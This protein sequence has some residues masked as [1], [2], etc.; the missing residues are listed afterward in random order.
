MAN[1]IKTSS[2]GL[3]FNSEH[4]LQAYCVEWF[5]NT[6]PRYRKMLHA[7][8]N[9]SVNNVA[10][11]KA[12]SLGVCE[13]VCD[14][15]FVSWS[16]RVIFIEMKLPSKKLSPP[17]EDFADKLMEREHLFFVVKTF[18]QFKQI[19]EDEIKVWSV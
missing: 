9:N 11:N 2:G 7:N 3:Q 17:Q 12:R 6:Y 14:L 19:I 13:G 16:G 5:W 18:E 4:A 8:N 10:G 1:T 15:E